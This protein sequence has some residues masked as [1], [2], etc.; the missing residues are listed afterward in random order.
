MASRRLAGA[1]LPSAEAALARAAVSDEQSEGRVERSTS[2]DERSTGAMDDGAC[3]AKRVQAAAG[4]ASQR[5]ARAPP[6]GRAQRRNRAL[7]LRWLE[8]RLAA[9]R[10][11][12]G[13][14]R[15]EYEGQRTQHERHR[16]RRVHRAAIASRRRHGEPAASE[17]AAAQMSAATQPSTEAALARA[18]IS[19]EQ[20][21]GRVERARALTNTARAPSATPRASRSKRGPPPSWRT[22]G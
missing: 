8:P 3:I 16:R 9:S 6:R 7:R 14:S 2:T 12:D 1:P 19:G 4:M 20:S 21:E 13:S 22:G 5:R 18:A 17:S 11:R 15:G 10:A